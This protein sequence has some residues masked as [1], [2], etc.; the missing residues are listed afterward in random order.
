M[1]MEYIDEIYERIDENSRSFL[2][3]PIAKDFDYR[4]SAPFLK[5][6]LNNEWD[7]ESPSTLLFNTKSIEKKVVA[8]F[9]DI[10]SIDIEN[11]WGF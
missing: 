4:E 3:Y 8:F 11:T 9:A 2:G 5:V 7:P 6:C 10:L 1:K